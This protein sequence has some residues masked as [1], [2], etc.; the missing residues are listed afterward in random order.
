MFKRQ[1]GKPLYLFTKNNASGLHRRHSVRS[2]RRRRRV[3]AI[4]G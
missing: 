3:E 2:R 4:H 1:E